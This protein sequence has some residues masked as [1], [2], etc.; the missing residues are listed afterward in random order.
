ATQLLT[1]ESP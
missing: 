1:E